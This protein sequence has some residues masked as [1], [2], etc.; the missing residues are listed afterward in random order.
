MLYL[1][2]HNPN[3]EISHE[4]SQTNEND[5]QWPRFLIMKAA[6]KN[7]PLNLNV[8]TLRKAVDGMA[9][10]RPKQC[11]PMKSSSIF[12]EVEKKHQSKNLLRI[13]MLMGSIP[14]KVTPYRTLNLRNL[15]SNV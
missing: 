15:S 13:T 6:D 5:N 10:G 7:I 11:K 12:I 14:V 9:N 4:S 2:P 3:K 1:K 8:F